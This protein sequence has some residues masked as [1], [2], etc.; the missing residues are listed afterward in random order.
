M[1]MVLPASTIPRPCCSNRAEEAL[2]VYTHTDT[3]THW[4]SGTHTLSCVTVAKKTVAVARAIKNHNWTQCDIKST[5]LPTPKQ[6]WEEYFQHVRGILEDW[7]EYITQQTFYRVYTDVKRQNSM[8]SSRERHFT[9]AD[10]FVRPQPYS[11]AVVQCGNIRQNKFPA[12]SE[13]LKAMLC[14]TRKFVNSTSARI[15]SWSKFCDS[16]DLPKKLLTEGVAALQLLISQCRTDFTWRST[17]PMPPCDTV[18]SNKHTLHRAWCTLRVE[19]VMHGNFSPYS[20][21]NFWL[22]LFLFSP[23]VRTSAFRFDMMA[24]DI[25]MAKGKN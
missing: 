1:S 3:H 14:S 10:V 21:R 25:R 23:T 17:S 19:F 11:F 5:D 13:A 9:M 22:I 16:F 15:T 24:T 4:N 20:S 18:K 12:W 8:I 2:T 7:A 6:T